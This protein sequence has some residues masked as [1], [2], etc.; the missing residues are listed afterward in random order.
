MHDANSKR[1]APELYLAEVCLLLLEQ[2]DAL[3]AERVS[4]AGDEFRIAAFNDWT[5]ARDDYRP[6]LEGIVRRF[7]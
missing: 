1:R 7:K 6:L 3:Y 4:E 5:A 2:L